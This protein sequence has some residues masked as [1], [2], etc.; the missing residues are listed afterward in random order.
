M[1]TNPSMPTQ[2]RPV[3]RYQ[4]TSGQKREWRCS[5][6]PLFSHATQAGQ[7][8]TGNKRKLTKP[9]WID[10]ETSVDTNTGKDNCNYPG[11]LVLINSAY[12]S[13]T[14]RVCLK[15]KKS[16]QNYW[17]AKGTTAGMLKA[18]WN[19]EQI[20]SLSALQAPKPVR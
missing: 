4:R 1:R 8:L 17:H 20:L 7:C 10:K 3:P 15:K 18:P 19:R 11:I 16:I 2:A 9:S 12:N 13:Y 14:G 6:A 5:A